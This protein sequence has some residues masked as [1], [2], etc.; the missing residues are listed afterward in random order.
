MRKN[1][2]IQIFFTEDYS[3]ITTGWLLGFKFKYGLVIKVSISSGI[4]ILRLPIVEDRI[5]NWQLFH[6]IT[7]IAKQADC[8]FLY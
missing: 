6:I 1:K 3:L 5:L 8:C 2:L 4:I 7:S